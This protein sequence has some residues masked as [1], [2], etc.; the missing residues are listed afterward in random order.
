[1]DKPAS[2]F[3]RQKNIF[4]MEVTKK[5]MAALYEPSVD[6]IISRAFKLF[7]ANY[8]QQGFW[9]SWQLEGSMLTDLKICLKY[10]HDNHKACT[11]YTMRNA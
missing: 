1:M 4:K 7:V 11:V 6:G 5:C 10:V 3:G 2:E 9:Q 8:S